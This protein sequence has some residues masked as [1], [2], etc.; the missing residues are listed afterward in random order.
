MGE[1]DRY[2]ALWRQ[3]EAHL[4]GGQDNRVIKP[5]G[6]LNTAQI[7]RVWRC[8]LANIARRAGLISLGLRI[9]TPAVRSQES[10]TV[11]PSDDELAEYAILLQR[12]GAVSEAMSI[13]ASIDPRKAPIA[14][15]HRAFCHFN[16]WEYAEA[17]PFLEAFAAGVS[18]PY[19]RMVGNV[20]LSAAMVG[21]GRFEEAR[22]RLVHDIAY[23]QE[24]G[25]S[26]L[27]AS[28]HE[29]M[30]LAAL[31]T[32][33]WAVAERE[34]RAAQLLLPEGASLERLM[35]EKCRAA[36]D[37]FQR[38]S[39]EPLLGFRASAM[40][41][42]HPETVRETDLFSLHVSF[43]EARFRH[44]FFGTPFPR[45]RERMCRMLNQRPGETEFRLGSAKGPCLDL[46][47]GLVSDGRALKP[48]GGL[49]HQ[50]IEILFRDFYR[51]QRVGS[52]FGELFPG[53]YF[54]VFSSPVRLRRVLFRA[55]ALLRAAD[56]PI[57]IVERRGTYA[58]RVEP[59][60]AVS[61]PLDRQPVATYD[62][63]LRLLREKFT[64]GASF[65]AMDARQALEIS[66]SAAQ[67]FLVRARDR[68]DLERFGAG[69][70][71]TYSVTGRGEQKAS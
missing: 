1:A 30:S 34:I 67:R 25:Y 42:P 17:M 32:R 28:C 56:I 52:L 2:E 24:N 12:C 53:E 11:L 58:V 39:I 33:D 55:R 19:Q 22:G 51:P 38:G 9:L 14:N 69:A 6:K 60:F 66:V 65:S 18:D 36:L 63:W 29:L 37:A 45:Y 71:T 23:A 57:E 62:S 64:N 59:G 35:T 68:G 27:Q 5:L 61:V 8:R 70:N 49:C 15:L 50:T 20:N 40:A 47:S 10:E 41:W 7:P 46:Q 43:D 16:R 4:R 3:C 13:L 54:N 21:L 44:L 31:H 26:R 48:S